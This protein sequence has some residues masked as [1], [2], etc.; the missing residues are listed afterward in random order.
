[1]SHASDAAFRQMSEADQSRPEVVNFSCGEERWHIEL[2]H[3]IRSGQAFQHGSR[4]KQATF[5]WC[6]EGGQGEILGYACISRRN[7]DKNPSFPSLLI[8][9]LALDQRYQQRGHGTRMLEELKRFGASGGAKVI[10]LFVHEHNAQAISLY[11]KHGFEPLQGQVWRDPDTGDRYPEMIC[12][13]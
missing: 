6:L 5:L 8:T 1:M 13:L 4:K 10:E 7:F 2:N 12:I 9:Q 11:E 3:H